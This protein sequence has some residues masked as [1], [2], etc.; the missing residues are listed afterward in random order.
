[1]IEQ[2]SYLMFARLLDITESRNEKRAGPLKKNFKRLFPENKQHIR[3]SHFRNEGGDR[4]LSIVRDEFFPFMRTNL[5][6][7]PLGRY[8]TRLSFILGPSVITP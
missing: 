2:I 6:E 4:M 1:M 5:Q 8:L 7:H 3:W